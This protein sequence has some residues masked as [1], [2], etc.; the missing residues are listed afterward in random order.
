MCQC[1]QYK[2][3]AV[4]ALKPLVKVELAWAA[5]GRQTWNPRTHTHTLDDHC[6]VE[7][8]VGDS[9]AGSRMLFGDELRLNPEG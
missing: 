3:P 4:Q 5:P 1:L 9:P 6:G 2:L 8:A 7:I